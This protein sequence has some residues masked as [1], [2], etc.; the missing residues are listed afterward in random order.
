MRRV[1]VS[2]DGGLDP[3]GA[4]ISNIRAGSEPSHRYAG[5]V[6][7]RHRDGGADQVNFH[8]LVNAES[9]GLHLF[10]LLAFIRACGREPLLIDCDVK[11]P[12]SD[13]VVNHVP[14]TFDPGTLDKESIHDPLSVPAP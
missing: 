6:V 7:D 4:K 9:T 11:A 2:H 3:V 1:V 8:P 5:L 14:G 12:R 13:G 10:G